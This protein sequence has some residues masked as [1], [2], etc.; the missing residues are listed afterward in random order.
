VITGSEGLWTAEERLAAA[1]EAMREAGIAV[2]PSLCVY[3]EYRS[4]RA[5]ATATPLLT[6]ADR[7]TAILGGNNVIALGA[8]QAAIDLGFRL[9][10]DISIVGI[11]NVPWAALVRPRI[12]TV[13]Q[14]IAEISK[15]AI[16]WLLERIAAGSDQPPLRDKVFEPKMIVGDSCAPLR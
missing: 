1:I 9:P 4:D 10:D 12:T 6:R 11:D 3:A 14:P 5:Y 7:P 16:D 15:I 13:E 2:D 8:L